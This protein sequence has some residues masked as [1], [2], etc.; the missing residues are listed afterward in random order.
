MNIYDALNLAED[1]GHRASLQSDGRWF[2]IRKSDR[3]IIN[4]G[5]NIIEAV[6]VLVQPEPVVEQVA[7]VVEQVAEVVEQVVEQ[8]VAEPVAPALPISL[9]NFDIVTLAEANGFR[10]SFQS[11][12]RWLLI[13]KEDRMPINVGYDLRDALAIINPAPETFAQVEIERGY[14]A[15]E[16]EEHQAW[17]ASQV[18]DAVVGVLTVTLEEEHQAWLASQVF[19]PVAAA[20]DLRSYDE[21]WLRDN[22]EVLDD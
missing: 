4:I 13:R 11:D 22:E 14:A 12:G 2:L 6:S 9:T 5:R 21:E 7:E 8:V 18:R 1:S 19:D 16:E 3:A 20:L 15:L 10:A 17:L